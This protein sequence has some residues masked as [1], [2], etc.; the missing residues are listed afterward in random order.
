M[1][2]GFKVEK[3]LLIGFVTKP[4]FL[5]FFL[6]KTSTEKQLFSSSFHRMSGETPFLA[7]EA[8]A[9]LSTRPISNPLQFTDKKFKCSGKKKS[10]L[11]LRLSISILLF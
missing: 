2:N 9:F 4:K 8:G 11:L 5:L 6:M 7:Y 1:S 3:V 10:E